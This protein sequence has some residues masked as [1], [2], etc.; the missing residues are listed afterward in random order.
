MSAV[1]DVV[2]HEPVAALAALGIFFMCCLFAVDRICDTVEY[3]VN[4]F[5]SYKQVHASVDGKDTSA[6]VTLSKGTRE[7]HSKHEEE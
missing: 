6:E 5:C 1:I 2:L 7:V 3:I 4:L